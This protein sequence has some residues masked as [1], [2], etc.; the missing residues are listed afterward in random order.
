[1]YRALA[2]GPNGPNTTASSD[3]APA[4]A[5]HPHCYG[6]RLPNYARLLSV[7]PPGAAGVAVSSS[8]DMASSA[9]V[10]ASGGAA[11]GGVGASSSA[12]IASSAAVAGSGGPGAA[13]PAAHCM[14]TAALQGMHTLCVHLY[15]ARVAITKAA[16]RR[17]R[18]ARGQHQHPAYIAAPCQVT[19][20][21]DAKVVG[22]STQGSPAAQDVRGTFIITPVLFLVQPQHT[23]WGTSTSSLQPQVQPST[24][25]G[26]T[27]TAATA[28]H[29]RQSNSKCRASPALPAHLRPPASCS[30]AAPHVVAP[31]AA[32]AP[33]LRVSGTS[34]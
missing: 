4:P 34:M 22:A 23:A 18:R 1:M 14:R 3:V 24:H 7:A 2:E 30:A 16:R 32:A 26:A 5:L 25:C 12:K 33:Q 17:S 6:K 27:A 31:A 15:D 20:D 29:V 19:H 10:A 8:A 28:A 21:P 13:T 9:V 11:A